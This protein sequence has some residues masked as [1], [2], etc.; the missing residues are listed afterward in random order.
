MF[1]LFPSG[2]VVTRYVWQSTR[3]ASSF[4]VRSRQVAE[5]IEKN[6]EIAGATAIE[7]KL[8]ETPKVGTAGDLDGWGFV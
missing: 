7:D 8:Q 5:Q 4:F 2:S 1:V 6:L 3:Y